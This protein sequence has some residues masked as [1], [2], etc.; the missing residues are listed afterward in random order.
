M[1][2]CANRL[3]KVCKLGTFSD[4]ICRGGLEVEMEM[5]CLVMFCF[6]LVDVV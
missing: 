5:D 2:V 6:V 4:L 3:Q 1:N